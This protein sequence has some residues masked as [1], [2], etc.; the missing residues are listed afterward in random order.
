[1]ALQISAR[2]RIPGK[3]VSVRLGN[4]MAQIDVQVGDHHLVAAI[5]RDSAEELGLQE[6]DEVIAIIKSTDVMLGKLETEDEGHGV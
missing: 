1:M 3:V 6:G 2:N 4:V 5:T